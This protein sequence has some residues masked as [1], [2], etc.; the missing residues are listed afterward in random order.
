MVIDQKKI[1]KMSTTLKIEGFMFHDKYFLKIE[2]KEKI[3]PSFFYNVFIIIFL[4]SEISVDN[5]LFKSFST[6][7]ML[8]PFSSIY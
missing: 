7:L 2:Y 6:V 3:R 5:Q 8:T 4:Y 1:T